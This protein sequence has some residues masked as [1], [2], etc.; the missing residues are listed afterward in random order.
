MS[1]NPREQGDANDLYTQ[2]MRVHRDLKDVRERYEPEWEQINDLV[3]PRRSD[4]D[5]SKQPAQR[6]RRQIYNPLPGYLARKAADGILGQSVNRGQDWFRIHS[7]DPQVDRSRLFRRYVEDVEQV[8][9]A[10]LR[11][12]T[13]YEAA[14]D[15]VMDALT[16]GH[17][18]LHREI[19]PGTYRVIYTARHPKE[20]YIASNRYGE[21]DTVVREFW[22]E[23]R[24]I[25]DEFGARTLPERFMADASTSPYDTHK[26]IHLVRPRR[27]RDVTKIDK[28]N[29]PFESIMVLEKYK[30]V[31]RE[32]GYRRLPYAAIWRWRVNTGEVYARS[33]SWDALPDIKRLNEIS[34]TMISYVQEAADPALQYPLEMKGKI[35]RRPRGMTPY[36]D[37]NR[38][39]FRLHESGHAYPLGAD[40]IQGIEQ[41]ISEAFYAD[42]FTVLTMHQ[43][44]DRTATEVIELTNERTALLSAVIERFIMEFATPVI[45][46]LYQVAAEHGWI[47]PKPEGLPDEAMAVQLEFLGPLAQGQKRHYNTGGINAAIQQFASSAQLWPEVLDAVDP[48]ELGR[49]QA[50]AVG[51]PERVLRSPAE[52]RR[53]QES[54]QRMMQEQAEAER[55]Q[56]EAQA[57][58]QMTKAPEQGSPVE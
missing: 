32:S 7:I 57:Y 26:V 44:K 29:M 27:D 16:V 22:M 11:R 56:Q 36:T 6:N 49:R 54:R 42:V 14:H 38:R 34:K 55:Q 53:I 43:D 25:V 21:V 8:L 13:L 23:A 20:V 47:P 46:D 50:H 37:P 9:F 45:S 51:M 15:S 2:V 31:L 58:S 5:W 30:H 24:E 17:T 12:S 41:Q 39:V 33:P 28:W 4:F 18:C 40:L 35:D 52:V 3:M 48:A 1:I 10:L 19:Q